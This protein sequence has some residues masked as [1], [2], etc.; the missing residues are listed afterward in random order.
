M[1]PG[2][3]CLTVLFELAWPPA[4]FAFL[5]LATDC[6]WQLRATGWAMLSPYLLQFLGLLIWPLG[7]NCHGHDLHV[8]IPG[9]GGMNV[10]N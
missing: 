7:L 8:I 5:I 3:V 10:S 6:S 9:G 1:R 4:T 2:L